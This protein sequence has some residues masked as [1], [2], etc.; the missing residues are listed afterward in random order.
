[1]IG[2]NKKKQ[3]KRGPPLSEVTFKGFDHNGEYDEAKH[4][5]TDRAKKEEAE[6]LLHNWWMQRMNP[7][8][9]WTEMLQQDGSRLDH[10]VSGYNAYD[11]ESR[12]GRAMAHCYVNAT[13][14]QVAGLYADARNASSMATDLLET[15]YTAQVGV[16]QIPIPIPTISDRE[17]LYRSVWF[18][19]NQD[20]SLVYLS[21]TVKD[22][23]RPAEGGKVGSSSARRKMG[24][25]NTLA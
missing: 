1:V 20:N 11:H 18:R 19:H 14:A 23:R 22:E 6:Q 7:K 12:C 15:S 25:A 16:M 21:Y 5:D 10:G 2:K 9:G 24:A 8:M 3:K 17:S 13:P 4:T